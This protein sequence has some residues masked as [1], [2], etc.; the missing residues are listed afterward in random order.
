MISE[1]LQ[2]IPDRVV[3]LKA[4]NR[5]RQHHTFASEQQRMYIKKNQFDRTDE[6][7]DDSKS[8]TTG[9]NQSLKKVTYNFKWYKYY[10]QQ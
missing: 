7:D 8:N 4:D 1:P 3:V 6:G 5:L 10:Q 9:E 2:H